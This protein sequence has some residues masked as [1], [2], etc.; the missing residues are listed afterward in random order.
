MPKA[1]VDA[2]GKLVKTCSRCRAL[3]PATAEHYGAS[4]KDG[5]DGL[6]GWC[7]V[8]VRAV[9]REIYHRDIE[10][11]R[12]RS[13]E[14]AKTPKQKAAIRRSEF[15]RRYGLT[16]ER[17]EE[18]KAE[19]NWRC[20]ICDRDCKDAPPG[21][22]LH[23]DHCHATGRVRGML[24]PPCNKVLGMMQD[25]IPRLRRAIAYLEQTHDAR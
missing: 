19:R 5:S 22:I 17:V 2:N 14:R 21:K 23:V 24:C 3:K 9:S 4:T 12:A 13:R 8:C 18:M 16:P 11:E 10:K 6:R 15:K 25:E 1:Y 7:R 20:D